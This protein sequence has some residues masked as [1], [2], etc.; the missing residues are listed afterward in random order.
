MDFT[1]LCEGVFF[2]VSQQT[3]FYYSSNIQQDYKTGTV[4]YNGLNM[5][6]DE[7]ELFKFSK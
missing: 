2:P 1:N 5:E 4:F 7:T 3:Q 6:K